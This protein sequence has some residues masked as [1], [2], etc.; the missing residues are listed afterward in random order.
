MAQV[1]MEV[2]NFDD[3]DVSSAMTGASIS[4]TG[5]VII[6]SWD[7]ISDR[8]EELDLVKEELE[9]LKANYGT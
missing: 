2:D 6:L 8:L 1:L 5:K 9:N 3:I 7:N 4:I